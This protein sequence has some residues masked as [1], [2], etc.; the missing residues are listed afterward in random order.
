MGRACAVGKICIDLPRI[1]PPR[2]TSFVNSGPVISTSIVRPAVS[3]CSN[4]LDCL[5]T[6][7]VPGSWDPTFCTNGTSSTDLRGIV[8]PQS[9]ED[10]T[11]ASHEEEVADDRKVQRLRCRA[12]RIDIP[13]GAQVRLPPFRPSP[14]VDPGCSPGGGSRIPNTRLR[15]PGRQVLDFG[16]QQPAQAERHADQ[17]Q[18]SQP[19]DAAV[20]RW[21]QALTSTT[22]VDEPRAPNDD[23][24]V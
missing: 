4:R 14:S 24:P 1:W 13:V 19:S 9:H 15:L 23:Q 8:G 12:A 3:P 17:H 16:P 21:I 10:L 2:A 22:I 18:C 5:A 7:N 6:A 11:T 20:L